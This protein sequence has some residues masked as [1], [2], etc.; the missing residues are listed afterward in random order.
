[1]IKLLNHNEVS[2]IQTPGNPHLV[3]DSVHATRMAAAAG[4]PKGKCCRGKTKSPNPHSHSTQMQVFCHKLRDHVGR[5][6]LGKPLCTNY[7]F[8]VWLKRLSRPSSFDNYN[9]GWKK[10]WRIGGVHYLTCM[11]SPVNRSLQNTPNAPLIL[12]DS[13]YRRKAL[14]ILAALGYFKEKRANFKETK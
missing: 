5:R 7:L 1:M 2:F 3:Q 8:W 9:M 11:A 4:K 6:A 13:N 10:K 14:Y 12:Y